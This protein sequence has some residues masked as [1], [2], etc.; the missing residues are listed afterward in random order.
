MLKVVLVDDHMIFRESLRK[1]L[2]SEKKAIIIAE[3][4]NGKQFLEIMEK[5]KPDLVLMDISM[6]LMD[7]IEA[8]Q[9]I[10]KKYPD[11]KILTLS[12]YGDE[13]HYF[14]LL[15]AG[16]KGF[17]LK[18]SGMVELSNAINEI[19][20]GGSWFSREL[21]QKVIFNISKPVEK[22]IDVSDREL[23]VLKF[24]CEG[25]TN[26]EIADKLHLS[27]ETIKWH[28]NNL[29]SKTGCKNTASLVMYSIKN[30]LIII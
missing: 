24:V 5:V 1:L 16:V 7:G 3:A 13:I 14:K 11:L 6:P 17:V 10:L 29:L 12:S 27:S 8:S 25:F 15:D 18:S 4:G 26:D 19:V 30:K 9:I 20:E 21:L 22:E 23:E 28:R 2:E